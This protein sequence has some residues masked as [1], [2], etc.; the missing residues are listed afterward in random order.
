M[1][2]QTRAV[3]APDFP[4]DSEWINTTPLRVDPLLTEGPLLVEFWDF[5]RVNSLRT[6]P[7]VKQWRERY[8]GAG[9]SVV[10]VHASAWTFANDRDAVASAADRLQIGHPI[11]VDDQF[12]CWRQYGTRGWPAR[13]LWG[14]GGALLYWHYGEG[15]YDDCELAIRDALAEY[16]NQQEW[17]QLVEPI[18]PEDI[19][20]AQ[21][22]PQT[23]DI[24]LPQERERVTLAG[25][26]VEG[27]DFLEAHSADASIEAEYSGGQAWAVLSGPGT[28]Y[29][30]CH[31][32]A[33]G[34]ETTV[35]IEAAT[36]G[37][38]VHGLQFTPR[39]PAAPLS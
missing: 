8:A 21:L 31:L 16:G 15:D 2:T 22:E 37:M 6:L 35:K 13:F 38:R 12:V 32:L 36:P 27:H 11:L 14:R 7:Y 9:L 24:A 1:R 10:S 20:G 17:P 3:I 4:P 25:D 19:P 34:G 5:A 29:P 33:D 39:P 18:R 26:W 30:G 28:Q 23:A